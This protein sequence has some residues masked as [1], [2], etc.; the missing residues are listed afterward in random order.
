MSRGTG[1]LSK[2]YNAIV[3][4]VDKFVPNALQPLWQSP[5][6]PKTVFFW[7][8]SFKWLLVAAG[9]GDVINR[10]P[11]LISLN[12]ST[13]LAVTG[14][15]YSRF[16]MVII[17][18]NYNL[19]AVNLTVATVQSYLI[20]KHLRWRSQN[21]GNIVFRYPYHTRNPDDCW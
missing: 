11:Q 13:V 9:L 7:G 6:G 8:P 12:Q 2:L 4:S 3:N 15:I 20:L 16:A 5:A 14:L 19:L 10:P 18:K 1:P 21:A 17:P